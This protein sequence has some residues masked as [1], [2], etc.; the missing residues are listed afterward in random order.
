MD[1]RRI[2]LF[3]HRQQTLH[4][5]SHFRRNCYLEKISR[6]FCNQYFYFN[7][8]KFKYIKYVK[9]NQYVVIDIN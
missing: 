7:F 1:R 3:N 8:Y 9:L 4:E 2:T 6:C 5:F